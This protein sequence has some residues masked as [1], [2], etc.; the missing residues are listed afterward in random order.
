MTDSTVNDY[1]GL[2]TSKKIILYDPQEII[3][4]FH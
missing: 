3:N 1:T 4:Y 2:T